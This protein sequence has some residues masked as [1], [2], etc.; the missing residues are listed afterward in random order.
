VGGDAVAERDP[1]GE[2]VASRNIK[3]Y[4]AATLR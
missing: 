3:F 4:D 1:F 2:G